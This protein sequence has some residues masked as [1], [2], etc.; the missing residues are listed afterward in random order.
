[1]SH[2]GGVDVSRIIR[3]SVLICSVLQYSRTQL[4]RTL[5]DQQYMFGITFDIFI[6]VKINVVK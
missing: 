1:M 6:T 4:H 3:K 5:R 2:Y